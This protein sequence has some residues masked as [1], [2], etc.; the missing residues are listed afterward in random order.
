MPLV[1]GVDFFNE[2]ERAIRQL[3]ET[4]MMIPAS[5]SN[6]TAQCVTFVTSLRKLAH[7]RSV[8]MCWWYTT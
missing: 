3:S 2:L 6:P 4:K 7:W 1:E 5:C 8:T